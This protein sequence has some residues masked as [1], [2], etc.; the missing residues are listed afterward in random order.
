ML[1]SSKAICLFLAISNN[2]VHSDG[3]GVFV[4]R[5]NTHEILHVVSLQ[6][7]FGQVFQITLGELCGSGNYNFVL[8]NRNGNLIIEKSIVEYDI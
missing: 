8:F 3:V 7:L 4:R 6:V 5:N 1:F 2:L